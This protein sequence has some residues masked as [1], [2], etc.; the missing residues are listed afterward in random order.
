MGSSDGEEARM[1]TRLRAAAIA[2]VSVVVISVAAGMGFATVGD[3]DAP[4]TGSTLRR[5]AAAALDATGG[6][7]VV[8]T[9][10]GD[11]EGTAYEVEVRLPDQ[12]Q[13][14]V[15]LDERFAVIATATDDDGPGD[16]D[17][18]SD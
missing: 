10:A 2:V 17:D 14:E 16:A 1:S 12:S 18:G 3:D 11:D 9:E 4:L 8:G 5:A 15:Q 6:G 13:V 7:E